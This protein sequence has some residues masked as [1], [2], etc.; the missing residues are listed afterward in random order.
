MSRGDTVV[1]WRCDRCGAEV[2]ACGGM[3]PTSWRA[4]LPPQLSASGSTPISYWKDICCDCAGSHKDWWSGGSTGAG[5]LSHPK[6]VLLDAY[7]PEPTPPPPDMA[8]IDTLTEGVNIDE[9]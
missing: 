3:P 7:N 2:P 4:L 9:F 5:A 8:L 6:L 1:I